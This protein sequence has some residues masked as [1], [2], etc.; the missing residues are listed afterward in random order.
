MIIITDVNLRL[1]GGMS[2]SAAAGWD[3]VSAL[4]NI[5]LKKDTKDVF[6]TLPQKLPVQYVVRAY[7]DI[8]TK[9]VSKNVAF[10][11]DGTLLD[12]RKRHKVV[13]DD[14]LKSYNISIDTSDL[15]E[16]KRNKKNNIEY[17]TYKGLDYLTA[18]SIQEEWISNIENDKYLRLDILYPYTIDLINKHKGANLILITARNKKESVL[19]QLDSL[20]LSK[21]FKD[22]FVVPTSGNVAVKKA[23]ILIKQN[24]DLIYGDTEVDYKAAKIAN[25]EFIFCK[26]GFRSNRYII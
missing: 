1:A 13:L 21:F 17:L 19:K 7:T 2:L 18:K 20:N 6:A 15:I 3:E 8:V 16:F 26:N 11:L 25:I 4:A 10:D 23:E 22:I 24:I 5:M 12:S 14:I 9:V